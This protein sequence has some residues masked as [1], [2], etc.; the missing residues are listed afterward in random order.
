MTELWKGFSFM[1]ID[2]GADSKWNQQLGDGGSCLENFF[3]GFYSNCD[4]F[5]CRAGN[6]DH[7]TVW[8]A[9][10]QYNADE[11]PRR[12]L[13]MIRNEVELKNHVSRCVVCETIFKL[14]VVHSMSEDVPQC[15]EGYENVESP[16][17]EL[18]NPHPGMMISETHWIGFSFWEVAVDNFAIGIKTEQPASCLPYYSSITMA[19]CDVEGCR[20][21]SDTAHS[22]WMMDTQNIGKEKKLNNGVLVN[23]Q[24]PFQETKKYVSRCKVCR[25]PEARKF[26]FN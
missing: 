5:N 3:P 18:N 1:F 2:G 11:V 16:N 17:R 19:Q 23:D 10:A 20:L 8:L 15:P 4:G 24:P 22:F 9:T 6:E 14:V 21:R 26:L 7:G 12:K 25:R 13:D